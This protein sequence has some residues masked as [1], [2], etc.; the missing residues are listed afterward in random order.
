MTTKTLRATTSLLAV[1]AFPAGAQT[2]GVLNTLFVFSA[3]EC[4][5]NPPPQIL[6]IS[7][8]TA[9]PMRWQIPASPPQQPWLAVSPKS[10]TGRDSVILSV[11]T[12][13]NSRCLP[14]GAYQDTVYIADTSG[15]DATAPSDS[16]PVLLVIRSRASL[17]AGASKPASYLVE[18]SYI[19]YNGIASGVPYCRVNL[20][21]FDRLIGT[22][23]GIELPVDE[24][25]VYTG[26]LARITAIDFCESKGRR[27]PGDDERDWCAETLI[28]RS[29]INVELKVYGDEGRGAYLQTTP[30]PGSYRRSVG[31]TCDPAERNEIL[32]AYPLGDDGGGGSPN[33]QQIDDAK[34]VDPSGRPILLAP[35]GIPSLKVGT[36]PPDVPGEGWTLRVIRKL[37]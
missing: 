11:T 37:P 24:D 32:A 36:Y 28:G 35:N 17:G 21:G 15:A 12:S 3:F 13:A 31:G 23:S 16:I 9:G 34:A 5:P 18:L 14:P 25:I 30:G 26:T 2:T 1:F 8:S 4:D 29:T 20:L 33:G 22:V 7:K 27:Y 10:G 19:G 6:H